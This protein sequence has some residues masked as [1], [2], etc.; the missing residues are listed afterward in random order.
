MFKWVTNRQHNKAKPQGYFFAISRTGPCPDTSTHLSWN[1]LSILRGLWDMM[2]W[3]CVIWK[4]IKCSGHVNST[5]EKGPHPKWHIHKASLTISLITHR[6]SQ[7]VRQLVRLRLPEA[8]PCVCDKNNR[9]QKLSLRVDQLLKWLFCGGDWHPATDEHAIDVE[10][11]P[12]AWLRLWDKCRF[13]SQTEGK[14]SS[15]NVEKK[16]NSTTRRKG[17]LCKEW[18]EL[19]W[20]GDS[21]NTYRGFNDRSA[22]HRE[23]QSEYWV[24]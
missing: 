23:G 9:H 6:H 11:Q 17:R 19:G 4:Q 2:T 15:D 14:I 18:S 20:N 7:D 5:S 3:S 10:Q 16:T 22:S 1:F 8:I 24:T 21:L 12:E 13:V